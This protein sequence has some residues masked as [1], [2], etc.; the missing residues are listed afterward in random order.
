MSDS[1]Q[2]DF[3]LSA[4]LLSLP[5]IVQVNTVPCNFTLLNNYEMIVT[6]SKNFTFPNASRPILIISMTNIINP[7]IMG[8]LWIK[9]LT[10]D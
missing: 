2:R 7:V 6:F 10:Y 3:V 9:I 4:S 8:N 5:L 1:I